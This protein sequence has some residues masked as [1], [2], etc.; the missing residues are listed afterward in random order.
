MTKI[1]ADVLS[2]VLASLSGSA[3]KQA[4]TAL[5]NLAETSEEFNKAMEEARYTASIL[6]KD[7]TDHFVFKSAVDNFRNLTKS[8]L[9]WRNASVEESEKKKIQSLKELTKA[10][11]EYYDQRETYGQNDEY[12]Q[13]LNELQAESMVESM[14]KGANSVQ[15]MTAEL[16]GLKEAKDKLIGEGKENPLEFEIEN[17][18]DAI[19]Q[20]KSETEAKKE[21]KEATQALASAEAE[22]AEKI[23]QTSEI[24]KKAAEEKFAQLKLIANQIKINYGTEEEILTRT[25]EKDIGEY[26]KTLNAKLISHAEYNDAVKK[27][28]EEYN[29][30]IDEQYAKEEERVKAFW[31]EIEQKEKN[32]QEQILR[33]RE[34]YAT[35][36]AERDVVALER[37]EQKYKEE[38]KLAEENGIARVEVEKAKE[39][40]IEAIKKKAADKDAENKKAMQ[41]LSWQL[42]ETA[43]TDEEERYSI[44]MERMNAKYDAEAEKAKDNAALLNQIEAARVAEAE[45]LEN[46]LLQTRLNVADQYASSMLQVVKGAAVVG[47]VNGET[48]KAIAI[49]EAIINTALAAT[50]AMTSAPWPLSLALAAG[51]TASGMAQVATIKA[52]KFATG[53]IVEGNSLFGD[54]V[55]VRANSGEMIFTKDQQKELLRKANGESGDSGRQVVVNFAP[56]ISPGMNS[57]DV[58]KMLRENQSAFRSFFANEV[59]KG[60][61][62]AGVF[63]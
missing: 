21:S 7:I 12:T 29:A 4:I 18:Q 39:A 55:P 31:A 26:K 45:R 49:S 34:T 37:I 63:A 58:K 47:K 19:N 33:L 38:L 14:L 8:I 61:S 5:K 22:S 46:Q 51:A 20:L 9:D 17:L 23:R 3:A 27:R 2:G 36:D 44:Q 28:T 56:N 30:A 40:E 32:T 25:Y 42:R 11:K 57:E 59:S 53:G 43:A 13:H 48:M 15:I 16:K 60:L 6:A 50:K 52:Q 62:S 54:H 1:A 10:T 41:E 24:A 35:T